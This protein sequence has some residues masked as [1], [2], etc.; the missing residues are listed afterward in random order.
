MDIRKITPLYYHERNILPM[1]TAELARKISTNATQYMS[2]LQE[3]KLRDI[4]KNIEYA[5]KDGNSV[6]Y[7]PPTA[8]IVVRK[9]RELGYDAIVDN[10]QRDP[11]VTVTW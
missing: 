7:L 6:V 11:G 3:A 5:A 8:E 10:N 9:L 1:F 2:D 4:L